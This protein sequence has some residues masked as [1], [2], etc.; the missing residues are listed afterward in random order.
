MTKVFLNTQIENGNSTFLDYFMN[1]KCIHFWTICIY[2][3]SPTVHNS[4]LYPP[5]WKKIV[6]TIDLVQHQTTYVTLQLY[7]FH[8]ANLTS[9]H[10]HIFLVKQG[11][12]TRYMI[13]KHCFLSYA[14]GHI[15]DEIS[16]NFHFFYR[17]Y[18]PFKTYIQI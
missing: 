9:A 4:F 15:V 6:S 16:K 10:V 12:T 5:I 18:V 7:S 8:C 17:I 1:Q 3:F 14:V 2:F 13:P 11:I